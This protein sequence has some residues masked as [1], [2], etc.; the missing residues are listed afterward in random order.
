M[1]DSDCPEFPTHTKYDSSINTPS[2]SPAY[3]KAFHEPL[4]TEA[5][6]K[7]SGGKVTVL[8][9]ASGFRS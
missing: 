5:I 6:S 7:A 4:M 2:K 3:F 9:V 1:G 8:N